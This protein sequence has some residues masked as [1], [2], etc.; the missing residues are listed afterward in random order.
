MWRALCWVF[1]RVSAGFCSCQPFSIPFSSLCFQCFSS[2]SFFFFFLR[3]EKDLAKC[4]CVC[5]T[6]RSFK[7]KINL[8]AKSLRSWDC[9]R[10]NQRH[11]FRITSITLILISLISQMVKD[12]PR[13]T[14][15]EQQSWDWMASNLLFVPHKSPRL[16]PLL[17][18]VNEPRPGWPSNWPKALWLLRQS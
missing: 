14:A 4:V 12:L 1:I 7:N 16:F 6:D 8:K 15:L 9:W 5:V 18:Q 2:L 10:H 17:S 3:G 13:A 11:H